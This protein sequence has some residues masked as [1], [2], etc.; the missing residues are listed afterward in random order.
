[1]LKAVLF[2]M[3]GVLVDTEP[4]YVRTNMKLIRRFGLPVKRAEQR[5]YRG[6]S[7]VAM[8]R[9]LAQKKPDAGFDVE[10]LVRLE[11][12]HMKEYYYAG[13]LKPIRPAVRLLRH[14][15][16]SGLSIAIATSSPMD[17]A[18][19]VLRRL[20][21][22]PFVQAVSTAEMAG[23]SKPEPGIFLL[24]AKL[25]SV[26]PEECVVIE[27]AKMGVL[28]AKAAGMKCVGVSGSSGQDLSQADM[29]VRSLR[30]VGVEAL[31]RLVE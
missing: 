17:Y 2:D 23:Q 20:S 3:D 31:R 5:R 8:W 19:N 6:M 27:D 29:V 10:E 4:E 12:E 16:K 21:I 22:G 26:Q 9:D 1:M 11:H 7:S 14:C 30:G 15:A 13:P 25:L 28:A 18:E 24:A